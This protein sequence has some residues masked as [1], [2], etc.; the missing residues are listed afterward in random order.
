MFLGTLKMHFWHFAEKIYQIIFFQKNFSPN[1]P[2]GTKNEVLKTLPK[3]LGSKVQKCFQTENFKLRK[4][5]MFSQ[6]VAAIY[7]QIAHLSG[8]TENYT[9]K[10]PHQQNWTKITPK[11]VF[12][13]DNQRESS[14]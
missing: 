3:I 11:I 8:L 1:L 4:T 7:N 14:F 6:I 2:L 13:C 10:L 5:S 9:S 12:F